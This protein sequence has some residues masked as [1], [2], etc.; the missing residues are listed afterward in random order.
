MMLANVER[1]AQLLKDAG[2]DA[3]IVSRPENVRYVTDVPLDLASALGLSVAAIVRP[4]PFRVVQIVAPRVMAG[5]IPSEIAADAEVRLYGRFHA[6]AERGRELKS[7]ERH[8][9]RLLD[10]APGE[11]QTF[12]EA[13][14]SAVAG[15]GSSAALAWDEP[16]LGAMLVDSGR[17]PITDGEALIRR[18]RRV[19][20]A[21][22]I[23]RIRRAAEIAE[24][25]ELAIVA[26]SVPGADWAEIVRTIPTLVTSN[27]GTPGYFSGGAAWQGGFMFPTEPLMLKSGDVIRLDL[28]LSYQGYW[29]DTG[30]SI[31]LG[32]PSTLVQRRY[33]AIRSA[34]EAVL[35]A[36]RPGVAFAKLYDL[37]MVRA[38]ET[39]PE[40]RRH[41]CCHAIGLRVYEGELVGPAEPTTV[42]QGMTF[43]VEAPY[44]EIGWGG[45]QLEETIVVEAD[46]W[47]PLTRLGREIVVTG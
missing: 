11:G 8:A 26:A 31:S 37:A 35:E 40:F 6:A 9:L 38:R 5:S 12:T 27:G 29:A 21:V 22:E 46:G 42:E 34:V 25:V 32:D 44:Y 18:I 20:T 36:T 39:L 30:R 10:E 17:R 24:Q 28:G 16:T 4:D 2:V 41:H 45:L 33:A 14:R 15:F 19:K 43:N 3:L 1:G 47:Q 13:V 23:D 7:R